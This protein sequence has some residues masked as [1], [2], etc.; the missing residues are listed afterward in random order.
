MPPFFGDS[1]HQHVISG[2]ENSDA[3]AIAQGKAV[4]IDS[5]SEYSG[6]NQVADLNGA[7]VGVASADAEVGENMRVVTEGVTQV[8]MGED[9]S[10]GDL[11][12]SDA[13][14]EFVNTGATV[15]VAQL[16]HDALEDTLAWAYVR[17]IIGV[18]S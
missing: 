18:Q 13:N 11:L 3:A 16:L 8:Y 12:A 4:F 17:G 9:A 5:G 10:A 14:G 6:F 2:L 7:A 1:G 15:F